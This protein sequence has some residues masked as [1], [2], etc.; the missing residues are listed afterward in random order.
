[1]YR[2]VALT[3]ACLLVS[4]T[5][6]LAQSDELKAYNGIWAKDRKSCQ[7]FNSGATENF[8]NSQRRQ[9]LLVT[10]DNMNI[11]YMGIA[12][13]CNFRQ[14]IPVSKNKV[15]FSALCNVKTVDFAETGTLELS[16]SDTLKVRYSEKSG[17]LLS[18]DVVRCTEP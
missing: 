8:D 17:N 10:I 12:A 6:S 3:V 11:E 18:F 1:M 14:I 15:T 5:P 2:C 13:R 16:G 4:A 9:M 7:L